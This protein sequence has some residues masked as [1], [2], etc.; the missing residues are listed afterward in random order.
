MTRGL[1]LSIGTTRAIA[2]SLSEDGTS[3]ISRRSTLTF[4]TQSTVRLGDDPG[5]EGVVADFAHRPGAVLV[6]GD[7]CRYTGQDLI[8]AAAYCLVAEANPPKDVPIVLSTAA[9]HPRSAGNALRTALDRAGLRRVGLVAEPV[10][11]VACLE[12]ERGPL[13]DGLALVC[14]VDAGSLDLTVVA[15]GSASR[16]DPIVGRPLRFDARRATPPLTNDRIPTLEL[17]ADCLSM[18][19][20]TCD[21]LDVIVVSG[22]SAADPTVI[23]SLS[24]LG[25]PILSCPEPGSMAARGAAALAAASSMD[26]VAAATGPRNPWPRRA[27]IASVAAAV[28]LAMPLL[29][30]GSEPDPVI[31]T[32]TSGAPG[33][34]VRLVEQSARPHVAPRRM[35]RDAPTA[36][37]AVEESV[38]PEHGFAAVVPIIGRAPVVV[39]PA[40]V[41]PP[42]DTHQTP[43]SDSPT[44]T[45]TTTVSAIPP[46]SPSPPTSFP[47]PAPEPDPGPPATPDPAVDPT[48]P[49]PEPDPT[50]SPETPKPT[51]ADDSE[52][53]AETPAPAT[54]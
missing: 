13:G 21:D 7:G 46:L 22:E 40:A 48:T 38:L 31:T 17:V 6:A 30:R 11:A 8:V 36:P 28:V 15:I 1:G 23:Q 24:Q 44:S 12:F 35:T 14:N 50:T 18:A 42:T 49:R 27:A 45:P 51:P 41:A 39:V 2:V 25:R 26:D 29:T 20:V 54:P 9:A 53:D 43:D 32:A 52:P 34:G 5:G 10:A 19:E 47:K 3:T 37:A 33:L 4:G 16:S